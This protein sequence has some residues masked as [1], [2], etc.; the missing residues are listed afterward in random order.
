MCYFDMR[1]ESKNYIDV[2]RAQSLRV[3]IG[4]HP[5]CIAVMLTQDF[6]DEA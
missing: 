2:V 6:E 1:M 3:K 5:A 4:A